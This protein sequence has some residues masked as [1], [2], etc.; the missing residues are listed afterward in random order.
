M[1]KNNPLHRLASLYRDNARAL[2]LSEL[3]CRESARTYECAAMLV[4]REIRLHEKHRPNPV[5]VRG[6]P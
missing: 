3:A 4:E 2:R 6:K 1:N 5:P